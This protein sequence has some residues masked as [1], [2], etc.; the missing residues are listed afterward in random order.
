M[1]ATHEHDTFNVDRGR[2]VKRWRRYRTKKPF[3]LAV[4]D[5]RRIYVDMFL[6][7]F[8]QSR[9]YRCKLLIVKEVEVRGFEPLAFSLRTRRS[10]S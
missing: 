1:I 4:H 3:W 6:C 8:L 5:F 10:T 9:F 7:K 2:S